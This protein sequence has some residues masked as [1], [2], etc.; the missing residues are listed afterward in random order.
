MMMVILI[1]SII[2]PAFVWL[3]L[4]YNI[5]DQYVTIDEET[6]LVETKVEAQKDVRRRTIKS[7]FF[8]VYSFYSATMIFAGACSINLFSLGDWY[9]SL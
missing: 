7:P 2:M 6:T 9:F 4:Y 3:L 1:S 5:T 8:W